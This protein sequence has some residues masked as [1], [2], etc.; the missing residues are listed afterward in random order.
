[1][2]QHLERG[3]GA[4][5]MIF[6]NLC[7]WQWLNSFAFSDKLELTGNT[8][9]DVADESISYMKKNIHRPLRLAD[10]ANFVHL[11]ASHYSNLFRKKT[12]FAP[13][14]YFNLLKIQVAC[15]YLQFTN[16][17]M[18]EIAGRIGIEDPY[19]FSRLF[20]HIMGMAPNAYRKRKMHK[21]PSIPIIAGSSGAKVRGATKQSPE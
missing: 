8:D 4:D 19:Y 12:G 16:L 3:Y 20:S 11:S 1:M 6:V 21:R 10:I 18:Q 13:I 5:S 7:L 2:Y 9:G 14:E 17:R 15:Q